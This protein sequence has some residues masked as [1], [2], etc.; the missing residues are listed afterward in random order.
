M[1][2]GMQGGFVIVKDSFIY[3]L[4]VIVANRNLLRLKDERR[5]DKAYRN[6]KAIEF[7]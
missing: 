1:K 5:H 4:L 6:E 7:Q 3:R 2:S